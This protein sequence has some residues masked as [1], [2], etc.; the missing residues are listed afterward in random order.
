[1]RSLALSLVEHPQFYCHTRREGWEQ[2]SAQGV[3]VCLLHHTNHLGYSSERGWEV[4]LA[5]RPVI[6]QTQLGPGDGHL[7]STGGAHVWREVDDAAVIFHIL[8]FVLLGGL[9]VDH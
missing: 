5:W 9:H 2:G 8:E 4:F 6:A 1:M 7:V 3:Y